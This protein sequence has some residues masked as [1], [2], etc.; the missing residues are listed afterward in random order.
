METLARAPCV[1]AAPRSAAPRTAAACAHR[2]SAAVKR[3]ASRSSVAICSTRLRCVMAASARDAAAAAAPAGLSPSPPAAVTIR[4]AR[5]EDAPRLVALVNGSYRE[6]RF[7]RNASVDC[8]GVA[9]ALLTASP[10]AGRQLDAREGAGGRSARDAWRHRAHLA[11]AGCG[12]LRQ[13]AT[14]E[15]GASGGAAGPRGRLHRLYRGHHH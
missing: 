7:A 5:P 10:R 4:R 6:V 12:S 2:A 9:C 13:P 8:A 11:G 1:F 3:T 15:C 14:A